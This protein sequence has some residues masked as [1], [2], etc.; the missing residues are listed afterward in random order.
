[1]PNKDITKPPTL[2]RGLQDKQRLWDIVRFY[3]AAALDKELITIEEYAELAK[4][5]AAVARLEADDKARALP[6][7][8][9]VFPFDVYLTV[10][11]LLGCTRS[12]AKASILEQAYKARRLPEQHGGY[13]VP[14][15]GFHEAIDSALEQHKY[16]GAVCKGSLALGTGCMNCE[17]CVAERP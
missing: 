11:E 9:A 10:A 3:R 5:H 6:P 13:F 17:R 12:Q 14:D 4:D 7:N 15:P 16:K 8:T 1:M 2:P